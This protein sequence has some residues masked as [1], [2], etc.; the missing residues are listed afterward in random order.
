[1]QSVAAKAQ[2]RKDNQEIG[3]RLPTIPAIF[4]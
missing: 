3:G 4:R 2:W 1:M